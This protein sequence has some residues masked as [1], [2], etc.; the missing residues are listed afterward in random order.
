MG[1][2]L[3]DVVMTILSLS[4]KK[5]LE[6]YTTDLKTEMIQL[7]VPFSLRSTPS[8][9]MDFSFD[10]Q[11]AVLPLKLRLTKNFDDGFKQISEDMNKVK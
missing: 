1:G 5:Y 6:R 10:N 9:I 7:A 8:N 4:L 2:T 3:N 11:Y